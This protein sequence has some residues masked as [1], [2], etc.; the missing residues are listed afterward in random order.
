M[1]RQYKCFK[2]SM[3]ALAGVI[4]VFHG[5]G[6]EIASIDSG[7]CSEDELMEFFSAQLDKAHQRGKDEAVSEAMEAIGLREKV[8]GK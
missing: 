7:R 3:G 2:G 5:C 1:A 6:N 8:E 4:Q